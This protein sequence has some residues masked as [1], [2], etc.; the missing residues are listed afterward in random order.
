MRHAKVPAIAAVLAAS[1]WW[2]APVSAQAQAQSNP[3]PTRTVKFIVPFGPGAGADIGARLFADKLSARWGQPVVVENRPGGDSIVAIT[4]FLSAN[5]DHTFLFGPSGNFTVHPFVYSKLSYNPGEL[6]P[7][8]RVSNTILAVAVKADAPYK[9]V[10]GFT[11][12]ARAAPGTFNSGLV[13]G[14][15]EFTFWGYQHHEKLQ[16]TQVPYRDINV[17]PTDLGEGRIQ[18]VMSSFAIV[19]PQINAGRI[20]LLT[21]NNK[22]RVPVAP[23]MPT[24]REQGYPSLEVEGLVG[25]FGLKT[26]PQTVKDKI[27]ADFRAVT[28]DGTIGDRLR[29]T[30]QVINVGDG[31]G[32]ADSIEEQRANVAATVKAIDFKPKQ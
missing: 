29:A 14:I 13:Q 20:K 21:I 19:Q 30:G 12:A 32:F 3:W 2:F 16:I 9:D 1:L 11:E 27:A 8:A 22:T 31:K 6:V 4:A 26:T 28:A 24:A 5:D 10:K 18:V 23:D 15:T 17:A 7:I 25:L